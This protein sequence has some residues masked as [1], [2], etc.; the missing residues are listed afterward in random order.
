MAKR[1][2][3]KAGGTGTGMAGGSGPSAIPYSGTTGG[4]TDPNVP[5]TTAQPKPTASGAA[6]DP[7]RPVGPP[8]FPGSPGFSPSPA[9]HTGNI[10]QFGSYGP[11]MTNMFGAPGSSATKIIYRDVMVN[12][13]AQ[14]TQIANAQSGTEAARMQNLAGSQSDAARQEV[15]KRMGNNVAGNASFDPRRPQTGGLFG[16]AFSKTTDSKNRF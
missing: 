2:S 3:H 7:F 16:M 1:S 5:N 11:S 8:G 4:I 6:I 12:Q 9:D 14:A 10:G 13:D 15:L